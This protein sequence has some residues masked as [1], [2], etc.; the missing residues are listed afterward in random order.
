M[1]E[2]GDIPVATDPSPAGD[3]SL[4]EDLRALAGSGRRFARAEL[5]YQKAR[6][7]YAASGAR[8]VALLVALAAAL[9]FFALMALVMGLLL[10][11]TPLL[12]AWGATAIVCG[13][14][15]MIAFVLVRLAVAR[16]T[17]MSVTLS[18]EGDDA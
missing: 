17:R 11:L 13:G 16:W 7:S 9:G 5:D 15:A 18:D 6:V 12:T 14:L 2:D 3:R 8:T 1:T 10:A 4:A